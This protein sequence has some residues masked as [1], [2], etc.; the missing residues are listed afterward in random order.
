MNKT[1]SYHNSD[2]EKKN[3]INLKEIE[4]SFTSRYMLCILIHSSTLSKSPQ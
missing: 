1:F 3:V 2:L 4:N